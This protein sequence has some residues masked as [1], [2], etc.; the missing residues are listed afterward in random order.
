MTTFAR[1]VTK[2]MIKSKKSGAYIAIVG[3]VI[4]LIGA[5]YLNNMQVAV[6]GWVVGVIGVIINFIIIIKIMRER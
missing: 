5:L 4:Y 3:L 2:I 1:K 6:F